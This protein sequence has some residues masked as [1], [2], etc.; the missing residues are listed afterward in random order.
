MLT[1]GCACGAVRYEAHGTPW[2]E[3]LCHC[4]TCRRVAGAPAVAW[5]TVRRADLRLVAGTPRVFRSSPGVARGFCGECGTPLTYARD[6]LPDEIDVT[7]ASL[8]DPAALPPRDQTQL[9]HRLP[10]IE[11]PGLPGFAGARDGSGG[12]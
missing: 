7:T 6:D 5:F 1:G 2:H 9:A 4:P 8:D 3:T 10:W 12:A 11:A